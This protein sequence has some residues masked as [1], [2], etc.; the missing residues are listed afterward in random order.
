MRKK[1]K[2]R[3]AFLLYDY[4]AAY[5]NE[6]KKLDEVNEERIL[7]E[8]KVKSIKEM[9]DRTATGKVRNLESGGQCLRSMYRMQESR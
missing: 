6:L 4:E 7:K 2:R 3:T 8:G 5:Q 9:Q 1:K